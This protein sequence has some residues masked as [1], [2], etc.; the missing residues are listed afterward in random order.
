MEFSSHLTDSS[1]L[2]LSYRIYAQFI[3]TAVFA[4][5][6]RIKMTSAKYVHEDLQLLEKIHE[7]FITLRIADGENGFP[8]FAITEA[9]IQHLV[10]S[11]K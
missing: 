7:V 9:L 6:Q 8:P 11:V 3:L 2:F 10:S 4:L 5:Y 1:L